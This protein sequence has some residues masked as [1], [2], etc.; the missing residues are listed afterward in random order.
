MPADYLTPQAATAISSTLKALDIQ[1][2]KSQL[3]RVMTAVHVF[4]CEAMGDNAS[5]ERHL[6][7]YRRSVTTALGNLGPNVPVEVTLLP[8]NASDTLKFFL[9]NLDKTDKRLLK[10]AGNFLIIALLRGKTVNKSAMEKLLALHRAAEKHPN[11]NGTQS[12]QLDTLLRHSETQLLMLLSLKDR[13]DS[14]ESFLVDAKLL[15]RLRATIFSD[16][17]VQQKAADGRK[18]LAGEHLKCRISELL[19]SCGKDTWKSLTVLIAMV[20][21][22]A[23]T[24]AVDTP[25]KHGAHQPKGMFWLDVAQ[26]ILFVDLQLVLSE[27]GQTIPV[28]AP[29]RQ[30]F[31]CVCRKSSPICCG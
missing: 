15:S 12:K 4:L 10:A 13:A 30:R 25:L 18:F 20:T 11:L 21:G 5:L 27:L 14:N 23:W 19:E 17:P 2:P 9:R 28:H 8:P 7:E 6:G 31:A 29:T 22:L 16:H 3:T 1:P 24:I 26:G